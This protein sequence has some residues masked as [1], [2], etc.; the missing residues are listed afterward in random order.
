ME[1]ETKRPWWA[2]S[3]GETIWFAVLAVAICWYTE[4]WPHGLAEWVILPLA[5]FAGRSVA[6]LARWALGQVR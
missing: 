6:M 2:F 5:I 1:N 3:A 4:N